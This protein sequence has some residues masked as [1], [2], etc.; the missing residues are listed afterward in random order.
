VQTSDYGPVSTGPEVGGRT[1][2]D[3]GRRA[4][5][6]R[7]EASQQRLAGAMPRRG[8]EG[9]GLMEGHAVGAG[10]RSCNRDSEAVC[11]AARR[12]RGRQPVEEARREEEATERWEAM[13]GAEG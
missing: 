8:A 10:G 2:G 7:R 11:V 3:R 5:R 6:L 1:G 13:A 4:L 12:R 9:M